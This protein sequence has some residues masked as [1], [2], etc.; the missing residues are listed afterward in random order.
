MLVAS[1]VCALGLIGHVISLMFDGFI[2][3]VPRNIASIYQGFVDA[4]E[5]DLRADLATNTRSRFLVVPR[6]ALN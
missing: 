5:I 3:I 4:P 1:P 6:Y 2:G